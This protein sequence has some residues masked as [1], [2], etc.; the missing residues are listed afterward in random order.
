[1]KLLAFIGY[2]FLAVLS[3]YSEKLSATYKNESTIFKT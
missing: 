1:M 2:H 3:V